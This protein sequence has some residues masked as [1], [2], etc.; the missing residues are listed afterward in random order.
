MLIYY[1]PERSDNMSTTDK[2]L[3]NFLEKMLI[4][5]QMEDTISQ[6]DTGRNYYA[7]I[8]NEIY[9]EERKNASKEYRF[10]SRS[11]G[12]MYFI[13][14]YK[15]HEMPLELFSNRMLEEILKEK[16]NTEA[17]IHNKYYS[18]EEFLEDNPSKFLLDR[19]S[20]YD[21]DLANYVKINEKHILFIKKYKEYISTDW[22]YFERNKKV[23]NELVEGLDSFF[24]DNSRQCKFKKMSRPEVYI[25]LFKNN[26]MIDSFE[27]YYEMD[28]TTFEEKKK[29]IEENDVFTKIMNIDEIKLISEMDKMIKRKLYKR[30][31]KNILKKD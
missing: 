7:N 22:A 3:E 15:N 26:G 2:K 20:K 29:L 19:I 5:Y 4:E 28:D 11:M 24:D 1:L 10:L 17:L 21:E 14:N 25:Y 8:I 30:D 23:F 16:E 12:F 6:S 18:F 31:S 27:K 13:E 9:L